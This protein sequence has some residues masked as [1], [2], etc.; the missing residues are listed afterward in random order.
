MGLSLKL[1]M[2][3]KY[4]E[5]IINNSWYNIIIQYKDRWQMIRNHTRLLASI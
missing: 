2:Q 4:R 3:S 5:H 1:N